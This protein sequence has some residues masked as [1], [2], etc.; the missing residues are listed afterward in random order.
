[1]GQL[2]ILCFFFFRWIFANN[3][4]LFHVWPR[5]GSGCAILYSLFFVCGAKRWIDWFVCIMDRFGL[6]WLR[7]APLFLMIMTIKK[8]WLNW[9]FQLWERGSWHANPGGDEKRDKSFSM[10]WLEKNLKPLSVCFHSIT[11]QT[12]QSINIRTPHHS[13]DDSNAGKKRQ[14]EI[15]KILK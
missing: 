6:R 13:A 10:K 14:K 11:N 9:T 4:A 2:Y 15:N 3:F 7:H 12:S 8:T 5:C 1:M